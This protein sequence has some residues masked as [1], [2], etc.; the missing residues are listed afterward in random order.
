MPKTAALLLACL[1]CIP[2]PPSV[3]A[4]S[5]PGLKSIEGD[6]QDSARRILFSRDAPPGYKYGEWT[7]LDPRQ[8]YP[9]AKR[10]RRSAGGFELVELLYDDQEAVKVVNASDDSIEFTR[11][12]RWSG[13][14]AHHRCGVDGDQL[15]CTLSTACPEEG[16]ERL[17]WQGEERYERRLEC[18]RTQSRP[19]AQGI[20]SVCR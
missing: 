14:S 15:L 5:T 10:I 19:E 8:T 2:I 18:E 6:W 9:S 1:S 4:Q 12:N 17:V 3:H 13:C 16:A 20:P 11:T 7:A